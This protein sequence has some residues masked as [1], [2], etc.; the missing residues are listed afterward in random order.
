MLIV[1]D[2]FPEYEWASTFIAILIANDRSV[3]IHSLVKLDPKP[4]KEQI[5]QY[6]TVLAFE[7]GRFV[8]ARL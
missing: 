2:P 8:Q 4:T 1:N 7:N 5:A 6:T 3:N